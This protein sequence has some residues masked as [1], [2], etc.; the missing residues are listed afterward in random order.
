MEKGVRG[1]RW[2]APAL[3]LA[4]FVSAG[5]GEDHQVDWG[6]EPGGMVVTVRRA[7]G[8]ELGTP[9]S[10]LDLPHPTDPAK[11][12]LLLLDIEVRAADGSG[13]LAGDRWVRVSARPGRVSL[14]ARE[15]VTTSDVLLKDGVATG[16]EARLYGSFGEARLWASDVG[17]RP[18]MTVGTVS[19]C[20]NGNDD[21]GDGLVDGNDPGCLDGND[22]SEEAGTGAAGVSRP[23]WIRNPS[24][25]EL[26]GFGSKSPFVGETVTVDVGDMVVTRVTNDGMYV[27]DLADATGKGYNHLFV[28]NFNTPT[29]VPVCEADE[30]ES[31]SCAGD[32]PLVVRPCDRVRNVSGIISEFYG[33]TEMNFP[34]WDLALWDEAK[35]GPC[36]VPEPFPVDA[37]VLNGKGSVSMEGLEAA[38]VRFTD[39]D[40]PDPEKDLVNC[41][42]NG[43]GAVSFRNYDTN[44]CD[45]ECQ[46]DEKCDANALCLDMAQYAEFGQWPMRVGGVKVWVSTRT[47]VPSFDPLDPSVPRRMKAVTGT[48]RNL[49]FLRPK[50]WILEPRCPDD[51]VGAGEPLS[52]AVACVRPRTGEEVP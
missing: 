1:G 21:D 47:S 17:Y 29:S 40:L 32:K 3:V 23:L 51:L 52:S 16:V 11:G 20:S 37:D 28:F 8:G 45:E 30:G 50:P 26:Q 49:S 7:D 19:A 24:L 10:L 6:A 18:R 48:L 25:A 33:F 36:A 15:G 4:A 38:L 44:E 9:E 39:V 31:L 14:T 2:A 42:K 5:C 34:S 41:D 22:D 46:C 43:D 12:L 27:T 13:R 35:D